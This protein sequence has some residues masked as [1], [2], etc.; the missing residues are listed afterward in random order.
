VFLDSSS[1]GNSYTCLLADRKS[2]LQIVKHPSD[3]PDFNR[4]CT[5][6]PGRTGDGTFEVGLLDSSN[7]VAATD[8]PNI[9]YGCL[10]KR[11]RT[12]PGGTDSHV[13]VPARQ[14]HQ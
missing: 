13:H 4:L 3:P 7:P 5:A 6:S 10:V 8:R 1:S 9:V 14:G 2:F 12:V 11:H